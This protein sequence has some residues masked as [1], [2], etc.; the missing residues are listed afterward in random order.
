MSMS[1]PLL[2]GN[3]DLLP[4]FHFISC[5]TDNTF[6]PENSRV[7]AT[8]NQPFSHPSP[9]H[10]STNPVVA[11]SNVPHA[12]APTTH[13]PSPLARPTQNPSSHVIDRAPGQHM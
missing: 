10:P 2:S 13:I 11:D 9:S 6:I 12:G 8:P 5:G 3:I 7:V 1:Y 4:L